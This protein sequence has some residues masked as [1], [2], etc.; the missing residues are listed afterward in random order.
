M[1][2]KSLFFFLSILFITCSKQNKEETA[3]SFYEDPKTYPLNLE[4]GYVTNVLTG[5]T[6][7]PIVNR[8]GD[9]VLTG[10]QLPFEG[11]LIDSTTVLKPFETV[12]GIPVN[13]IAHTNVKAIPE[14]LVSV[15]I[16]ED[17]LRKITPGKNMAFKMALN[18]YGD[19]LNSLDFVLVNSTG[20]TIPTGVPIP[21]TGKVVPCKQPK[22]N[23]ALAF[24]VKDNVTYNLQY[25]D[26][27]QGMNTPYMK[28]SMEDQNGNLWFGT[29]D[30]VMRYDGESFTNYNEANG[31]SN[32]YVSS[33]LQDH[34]GNIWI[35]TEL[36]GVTK[37]DG[38]NFTHYTEKEGLPRNHV[39]SMSEDHDGNMWFGSGAWGGCLTK[40]DGENFTHFSI[41]E[42]L[43]SSIIRAIIEDKNGTIWMSTQEG[44]CKYDG[45][46][47]VHYTEKD[48][49]IS[50]R[51]LTI[52]EDRSGII[53][54][55]TMAGL[56]KYDGKS[57]TQ[58]TQNEGLSSNFVISIQEDA[59]GN[60]WFGTSG[61]G[62]NKFDGHFF[63]HYT[64][65]QGLTNNAINTIVEDNSGNI[66]FGTG[67]GI[68]KYSDAS[69]NHFTE[70]DGLTSKY[71]TAILEDKRGNIWFGTN[72]SGVSRYDG[73][74][75]TN[76]TQT[77][78]LCANNVMSIFEDNIGNIWVTTGGGVSKLELNADG[79]VETFYKYNLQ[80]GLVHYT[81][82]SMIQDRNNNLWFGTQVGVSMFNVSTKQ[83]TNYTHKDGLSNNNVWKVLEDRNGNI[84]FGSYGGGV[85][86]YQPAT[87]DAPATII[88][89]T[90][91]EG[92]PSNLVRAIFEDRDGNMWF[93][94]DGGGLTQFDGVDFT[95]YTETEGLADNNIRSIIQEKSGNLWIATKKGLSYLDFIDSLNNTKDSEQKIEITNL[96]KPDG[97]KSLFFSQNSAFLDSK[98]RIWWG[99]GS[100]LEMLDLNKFKISEN[101]P[102][103]YLRGLIINEK[104]ADFRNLEDSVKGK[105]DYSSVEPFENFP[106]N[107][108]LPFD[109][110]HLTFSYAAL[111]WKAPHKIQY[112]FKLE[113]L[114]ENWS[115]VSE[116]TEADYRNIPSGN[117]T[118]EVRAIGESKIWSDSYKYSFTILP[119][120]YQTW[121][122]RTG[123]ALL[124]LTLILALVRWR[125]AALRA[126]Q[127]QLEKTVEERTAELVQKNIIVEEQK[128]VVEKQKELVEEKHKEITDSINYAER[129]QRSFLATKSLLDENLKDYFV[130]FQPKD[131]VSGD[132]YWATKLQNNQFALVTADSTGHGVPGA[133]MSIL[134][135]TCLEK[136][137]QE[138]K[139]IEPGDIL[140]HARLNII[141]RLKKDGSAEG[142]K[143]G[144]DAS[145][146]CFDFANKKL[147]YAA[148]NNPVWIVRQN[149]IL[150]FAP[151]KMPVGK[152]DR[153]HVSFTSNQVDLKTGDVVYTLT[154]G[155]P[156]QFGGEKGK[157][158]MYKK[159]KELLIS[160]AS[161][162]MYL[163]KEKLNKAFFDWKGDLEQVDDVCVIGVRV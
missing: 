26:V 123:Y 44:V 89:Y 41:K 131:V 45:N 137:V 162:P 32:N 49:L 135:I 73:K 47:F 43:P 80:S 125:T 57:F 24:R 152:H 7:L 70:K 21:V 36:G 29:T 114:D 53:W 68:N 108:E 124:A 84:W 112:Q 78:G 100:A 111:D 4:E 20:D 161:D 39:M 19:S 66:W 159:L 17:S 133:I 31:L 140:N 90:E 30:G 113:G 65:T 64:E 9:T 59:A 146:V 130:L 144:M 56:S 79:L 150:E 151:D 11:H 153:Q 76:Y 48:G 147:N 158:F 110:N 86:K 58:I 148:A 163:Q 15:L 154:D 122:A 42:G 50:N 69:F 92:L 38:K 105:I 5:D 16:D 12:A 132:F 141:D 13:V 143:D 25:L 126:R 129:I 115:P 97:L 99:G 134:N 160:I 33:I 101:V 61:G 138:E 136:A 8:D 3:F 121:W 94:S 107:L 106:L 81:V 104:F 51:T 117:F 96:T 54:I 34:A 40:F 62:A 149:E 46:S 119:P 95:I 2:Q 87:S 118:F 109:Q 23:P 1:K 85:S 139:L 98:N 72:G 74:S 120:W 156:D 55:G 60:I 91:K 63:T 71:V 88:H 82:M 103:V 127:K 93:G 22:S 83:F 6:I 116:K 128:H 14:N 77:E 52:F 18:P 28:C 142:G 67:A 35:G 155:M 37:Y 10:V 102:V 27:D 145:L 75:F 157:K